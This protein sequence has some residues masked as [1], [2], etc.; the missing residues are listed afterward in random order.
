[1]L[2]NVYLHYVLDLWFERRF[3]KTCSG[4]AELTRLADDFVAAF[5]DRADAARFR[6]DMEERLTAF[7][8]RVA[9]EKTAVLPFDRSLLQGQKKPTE[10]P[11][12]FTFLGFVH[13]LKQ[14]RRG[15]VTVA[16]KPSIKTR[17][18]FVRKGQGVAQ[19]APT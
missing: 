16:R 2:S 18:R 10:K 5:Q 6:Q 8:L 19:G 13:Y 11:A 17:E 12:T 14:T 4:Y 1:V 7:G 9:P 3:K 15:G